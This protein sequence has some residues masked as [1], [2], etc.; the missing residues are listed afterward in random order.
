MKTSVILTLTTI[1][2][3]LS[4][5]E[6]QGIKLCINSLL[7]QTYD[8]YEIHFNIPS[9]FKLTGEE[10]I[11]PEWIEALS[12]NN[13]KLKLFTG[14]EDLGPSTKLVPTLKRLTNPEDI[15]IVVDDDLV[16]HPDLVKEQVNNQLK[17]PE[18]VVGYDGLRSKEQYFGDVRDYYYTSNHKDSRVDI[19]QHYKSVSYKVRYFES[20]FDEFI[21]NNFTWEDDLLISAY[22][23]FKKRNR[24]VT[25]YESDP[26]FTS[27]QEWQERGGVETFP[28][29]RHTHHES[30]EG[31]NIYRQ[32]LDSSK[33]YIK[34]NALNLHQF[35]DR[36]YE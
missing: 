31:C 2:S 15:I 7:N 8:D 32:D 30:Y 3:R 34:N 27:L 33:I 23:A 24:I 22:F 35:I 21:Q 11:I 18:A 1:P 26:I 17:F 29:L 36:G 12:K 6:D 9:H 28:V 25:Y 10:Y 13:P 19:I 4:F 5:L 16:Y 14:I 20:D